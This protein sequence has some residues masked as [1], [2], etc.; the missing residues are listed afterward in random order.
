MEVFKAKFLEKFSLAISPI[1]GYTNNRNHSKIAE[2][3]LDHIQKQLNRK[4]IE[5]I[6][7]A[8]LCRWL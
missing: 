5:N 4:L 8:I 7:R 6:N 3:W 1:S 2:T